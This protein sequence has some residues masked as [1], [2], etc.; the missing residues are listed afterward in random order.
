V[1]KYTYDGGWELSPQQCREKMG[2]DIRD[3]R[4]KTAP[5]QQSVDEPI[6]IIDLRPAKDFE[7]RHIRGSVSM[8]LKSLASDTPSP[9]V[10]ADVLERQWKELYAKF[11]ETD[12]GALGFAAMRDWKD[13]LIVCYT[14]DTA[15]VAS[16]ILRKKDI[17]AFSL[18]GGFQE[19]AH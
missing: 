6:K 15:R 2:I 4:P 16:S 12:C 5:T 1:D 14:G 11:S 8:P 9:F 19:L 3:V 13:V 7:A 10:S 18:R 17:Q